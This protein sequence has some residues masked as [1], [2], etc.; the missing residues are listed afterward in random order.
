VP[1][2]FLFELALLR[3]RRPANSFAPVL[4]LGAI[5]PH[6][7]HRLAEIAVRRRKRPHNF[8]NKRSQ[9]TDIVMMQRTSDILPGPKGLPYSDAQKN[10]RLRSHLSA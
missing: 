8:S 7:K 10:V 9:S 3:R 6:L 4:L 5:L 2:F 1:G